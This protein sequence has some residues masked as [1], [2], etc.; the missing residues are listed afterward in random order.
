MTIEGPYRT[1]TYREETKPMSDD[2]YIAK[3][4]IMGAL[5]LGIM[6]STTCAYTNHEENAAKVE[7][8]RLKADEAKSQENRAMWEHMQ[9]APL[10]SSHP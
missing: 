3:W 2:L 5:T 4:L 6:A 9:V 1:N 7:L 8:E 10:A